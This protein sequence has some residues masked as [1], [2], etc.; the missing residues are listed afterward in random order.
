[1][2]DLNFVHLSFTHLSIFSLTC[3]V[4]LALWLDKIIGEAERFH[5][6]VGFGKIAKSIE[7]AFNKGSNRKLK[8]LISLAVCILPFSVLGYYVSHYLSDDVLADIL[9][10]SFI[11]YIT[12]GWRSLSLHAKAIYE[13]LNAGHI[14]HARTAVSMIVSR[15]CDQSNETDISTAATESVLENGADA[16]F[17]AIFWFILAGVPGVICYRLTNTLDAMWGYKNPRFLNFGWAAARFDDIL[18][19]F[20]ARLTALSYALCGKTRLAIKCWLNQAKFWKSS[21]AGTV[22]ASGAGAIQVSLG[23]KAIYQGT[24]QL[25]PLLGLK[26]SDQTKATAESIKSA[27]KLINKSLCLWVIV[28]IVISLSVHPELIMVK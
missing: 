16:I 25:R 13:A 15:D 18:N 9:F 2:F 24:T 26:L 5:P 23:G 12:I 7:K 4:L 27:C 22:M 21:N 14:S 19:Y 28:L 10:S 6:L 11:L 3:C 8:G 20:P 1:M 17:G